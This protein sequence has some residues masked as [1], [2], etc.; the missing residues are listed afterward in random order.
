MT[1]ASAPA[2]PAAGPYLWGPLQDWLLIILAP[3]LAC[4]V[5]LGAGRALAARGG[6]IGFLDLYALAGLAANSHFILTLYRSHLNRDIFARTPVRFTAAPLLLAACVL[7]SDLCFA[8]L[9]FVNVWWDTWHSSAQTFGLGRI[10]DQRLGN[11]PESGRALDLAFNWLI[12][13][14]P[15]LAGVIRDQD[16]A[17]SVGGFG[18]P[19]AGWG[20]LLGVLL[21]K[22]LEPAGRLVLPAG[23]LFTAYYALRYRRLILEG[24]RYSG[25]KLAMFASTLAAAVVSWGWNWWGAAILSMNLFHT[26]QYFAIVW[27]AEKRNLQ[28]R[29]HVSSSGWTLAAFVASGLLYGALFM[30]P[31]GLTPWVM[32][33][34][35]VVA[36]LHF[37]YDG[38]IWSVRRKQTA[39]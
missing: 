16:I 36:T 13:S 25:L 6:A 38:F 7:A 34:G 10:Y 15:I 19:Y 28:S 5:G 18:G 26:V 29:F 32:K 3:L 23:L 27:I 35:I 22:V 30:L 33:L 20:A 31:V 21:R 8:I 24:Y 11:D 1:E 9:L 2:V 4:G 14:G 12:Y 17:M 37:W 39:F